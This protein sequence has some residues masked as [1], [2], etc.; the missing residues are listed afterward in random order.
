MLES[1][2]SFGRIINLRFNG[3][4]EHRTKCGGFSSI[5]LKLVMLVYTTQKA[6]KLIG[7]EDPNIF[8]TV[9]KVDLNKGGYKNLAEMQFDLSVYLTSRGNKK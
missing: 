9:N 5:I 2:D 8:T 4:H 7:R 6:I 1:F 3:K